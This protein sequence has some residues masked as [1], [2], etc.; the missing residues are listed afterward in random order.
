MNISNDNSSNINNK[1]VIGI[2]TIPMSIWFIDNIMHN[3]ENIKSYLPAAYVRWI[4][5]SGARV[6]P[7]QYTLTKPLLISELMQING[8]IICGENGAVNYL[9]LH[10]DA[11]IDNEAIRWMKA[12]FTIFE[13]AKKENHQDRHFPLLGIG[14]GCEELFFMGTKPK[15]YKKLSNVNDTMIFS[16]NEKPSNELVMLSEKTLLEPLNFS[17]T[18][19]LFGSYLSAE[20]KKLWS[21][22]KVCYH[23]NGLG[24]N[25][26]AMPNFIESNAI[27]K[28]KKHNTEY[29]NI[30]SFKDLPFYGFSF[31]PEA[32][33]YSWSD[34]EIDKSDIDIDVNFSKKMS[35]FFVDACRKNNA[36][37]ISKKILIYNY[38]LYS[39][40]TILKILYPKNWESIQFKKHFSQMYIFGAIKH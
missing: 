18:P 40:D 23:T 5:N 15:Y 4:E 7:L 8:A 22:T 37:L 33:L 32:V 20:D 16:E 28:N 30:F 14:T 27:S 29:V 1:P 2:L 31:H 26:N 9:D 19:G 3:T 10:K 17:E 24:L 13:F 12:A 35:C 34:L 36:K 6:V 39:S 21:K 38:T 11:N 25:A